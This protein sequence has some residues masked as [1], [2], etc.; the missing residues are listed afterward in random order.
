MLRTRAELE[1]K[2][3]ECV[4]EATAFLISLVCDESALWILLDEWCMPAKR[5]Q[6]SA[7]TL[8]FLWNSLG[9]LCMTFLFDWMD[10][11]ITLAAYSVEL[12]SSFP[13]AKCF[14][15]CRSTTAQ[16]KK[17]EKAQL[18]S[19]NN[20]VSFLDEEKK[21][22]QPTFNNFPKSFVIFIWS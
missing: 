18:H 10:R 15:P 19:T 13:L 22:M 16:E 21:K 7:N 3:G 2:D 4:L 5:W 6:K 12:V 14:W 11:N 8:E 9:M 20:I 1:V 17:K